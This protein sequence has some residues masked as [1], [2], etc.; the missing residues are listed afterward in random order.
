MLR[1]LP[2]Y[3]TICVSLACA[4]PESGARTDTSSDT[5]QASAVRAVPGASDTT[6]IGYRRCIAAAE[7]RALAQRGDVRRDSLRLVFTI[8][9]K[10]SVEFVDGDPTQE[11]SHYY[12]YNG[13][14]STLAAH[15]VYLMEYESSAVLYVFPRSGAVSGLDNLPLVSPTGRYLATANW[16]TEAQMEWNRARVFRVSPDSLTLEWEIV[17]EL[18]GPDSLRWIDDTTLVMVR[19]A[20]ERHPNPAWLSTPLTVRRVRGAWRADSAAPAP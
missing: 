20:A 15:R 1:R 10:D 3:A 2:A 14:D 18:W 4:S 13:W 16:D 6:C 9:G 19:G 5:S 12:L 11:D 17:P 7:P 8:P